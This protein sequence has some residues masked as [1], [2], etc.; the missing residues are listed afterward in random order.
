MSEYS[1]YIFWAIIAIGVLTG[2]YALISGYFKERSKGKPNTL[3]KLRDNKHTPIK[4]VAFIALPFGIRL[5]SPYYWQ[6]IVD[7]FLWEFLGVYFLSGLALAV[8]GVEKKWQDD[9][10]RKWLSRAYVL[11]LVAVL[12]NGY[13]YLTNGQSANFLRWGEKRAM[14]SQIS[15]ST[16]P[17]VATSTAHNLP[18][19]DKHSSHWNQLSGQGNIQFIAQV[20]TTDSV[21]VR[22]ATTAWSVGLQIADGRIS[23]RSYIAG[24]NIIVPIAYEGNLFFELPEN[25]TLEYLLF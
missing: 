22:N 14:Q 25:T 3:Q 4:A 23:K 12:I 17:A 1:G 2:L 5:A 9:T 10:S 16:E 15:Q 18:K 24:Q 7:S 20:S 6:M 13:I 8:L 11:L 19:V 21:F